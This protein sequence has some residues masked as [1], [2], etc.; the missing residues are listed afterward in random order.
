MQ[1]FIVAL[2]LVVAVSHT[3]VE[4]AQID[5]T[6]LLAGIKAILCGA[7]LWSNVSLGMAPSLTD[8][9]SELLHSLP[10]DIRSV[11]KN[12]QLEPDIIRYAVC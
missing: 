12:L 10:A 7:L 1:P 2:L 8:A 4:A 5:I 9:Q 11:I 3:L 6:F